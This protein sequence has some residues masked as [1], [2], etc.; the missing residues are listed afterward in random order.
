ME[1]IRNLGTFFQMCFEVRVNQKDKIWF[2]DHQ[3]GLFRLNFLA[4]KAQLR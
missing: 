1:L 4:E 3:M 2:L